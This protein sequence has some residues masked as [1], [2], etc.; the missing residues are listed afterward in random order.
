LATQIVAAVHQFERH[1]ITI[2]T[3]AA[4]DFAD[5]AP[6]RAGN[7]NKLK[8]PTERAH[9]TCRKDGIQAMEKGSEKKTASPKTAMSTAKKRLH[10]SSHLKAAARAR[11]LHG[12]DDNDRPCAGGSLDRAARYEVSS[13]RFWWN[14]N[15]AD[16]AGA[17]GHPSR[18]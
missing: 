5:C 3:T 11:Q 12:G 8:T 13:P 15:Q 6:H 7:Q 10:R 18:P 14:Q 9:K 16:S 17:L 1:S 2:I 4:K